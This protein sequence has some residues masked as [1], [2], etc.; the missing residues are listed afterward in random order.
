M[1][2]FL[3]FGIAFFLS[4]SGNMGCFWCDAVAQGMLWRSLKN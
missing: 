4:I 1:R 3:N 2:L